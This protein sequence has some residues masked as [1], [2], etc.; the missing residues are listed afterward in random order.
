MTLCP[1][2]NRL[3]ALLDGDLRLAEQDAIARHVEGCASC[4]EQLAHLTAALDSE[5]W[6][7]AE[8]SPQRSEAEEEMMRC[9]KR[10]YA[11]LAPTLPMQAAK[12]AGN[13]L[14]AG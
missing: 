4:R 2:H 3:T 7:R 14:G 9:L 13:S 6:R 1:S 10:R 5:T 8:H 12:S 11:E